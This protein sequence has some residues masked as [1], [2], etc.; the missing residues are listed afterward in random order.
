MRGGRNE[1][2]VKTVVMKVRWDKKIQRLACYLYVYSPSQ[3]PTSSSSPQLSLQS[4][5][6]TPT[7]YF[8]VSKHQLCYWVPS[9]Q[10]PSTPSFAQPRAYIVL[11]N[12]KAPQ[13]QFYFHI[14]HSPCPQHLTDGNALIDETTQPHGLDAHALNPCS[15]SWHT[16]SKLPSAL[17]TYS[18]GEFYVYE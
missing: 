7:S 16:V 6:P 13:R 15:S 2:S 10:G 9:C 17:H 3:L 11:F 1:G 5:S 14:T 12:N 8:P 18:Q 4:P